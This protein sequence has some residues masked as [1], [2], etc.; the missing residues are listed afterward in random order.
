MAQVRRSRTYPHGG[1]LN[2]QDAPAGFPAHIPPLQSKK[3]AIAGLLRICQ[4][5][6]NLSLHNFKRPDTPPFG[7]FFSIIVRATG[8]PGGMAVSSFRDD[9]PAAKAGSKNL[10]A[11]QRPLSWGAN[12]SSPCPHGMKVQ[13]LS[14]G[15]PG[16]SG[17]A[18]GAEPYQP[19]GLWPS[20]RAQSFRAAKEIHR[21]RFSDEIICAQKDWSP[22]HRSAPVLQF[23]PETR[24]K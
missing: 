18:W 12:R 14:W 13:A 11:M 1:E 2:A 23:V 21:D 24:K 10:T 3:P 9:W 5:D 8:Q 20:C 15:A 6:R 17:M 4:Q 22:C 7:S 19:A 16:P